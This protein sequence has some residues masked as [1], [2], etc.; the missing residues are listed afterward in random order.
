MAKFGWAYINCDGADSG[1]ASGPLNSVQYY[2]G[3]GDS[4][5]SL[6]Y[7]Y[8]DTHNVLYLTGT[9]IVSGAVSASSYHIENV[10]EMDVSGSTWFGNTNDDV[11]VRTGSLAV[12]RSGGTVILKADTNT[13]TAAVRGFA[14]RYRRTTAAS[15]T[16]ASGDYI[17][18]CSASA[19]QTV[20]LPNPST[21]LAGTQLLIKDEYKDRSGTKIFVSASSGTTVENRGFYVMVGTMPAINLYTDGSNWFVY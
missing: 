18:G 3:D 8:R 5:G 4:S 17:V 14:G 6:H 15:T 21:C 10:V 20:T 12:G 13:R 11:H 1:S 9:L 16:L 7:T 2:I 19:N